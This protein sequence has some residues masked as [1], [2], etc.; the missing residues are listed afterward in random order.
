VA[1]DPPVEK[2][3][4]LRDMGW[5]PFFQQQLTL[6][7]AETLHPA[8][9]FAIQRTH[10]T[11]MTEAGEIEVSLGGRWFQLDV[12]ERPTVGDWVLIPPSADSIV[13]LLDRKSLLKR[14]S[15]GQNS[16]VQLIGANIDTLFLVTSCNA[17]FNPRR[18]ERYLALAYNAGV[19][20]VVVLTKADLAEDPDSY[21][22]EVRKVKSDLVVELVNALEGET[23][24][25]LKG[26]C[27]TGQT[28][29]LLGSSGV[30]K[31]TLVNTLSAVEVQATQGIREDDGKGRHTTTHR[32][33]HL[34]PEG[35]LVLD[36]P[37]MRELAIAEVESGVAQMFDDVEALAAQCRFADCGHDTEPGCAVRGAIDSG[38][39]D[40]A[41]LTSYLK[42]RRE[43]AYNT[44]SIAERHAR[45]RD[46]AKMVK[47]SQGL[48]PKGR[49]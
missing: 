25:S 40:E 22:D 28:V 23:I 4:T 33:L 12:E 35:G 21:V 19:E 47:R 14:M 18:L 1:N 44:E 3:L 8:R 24:G 27:G 36:S 48:S 34:L 42:L 29:A 7:E 37:G 15:A 32:S 2:T 13:R 49:D 46:W 17:D 45:N 20:P 6:E 43:E 16:E 5:A 38:E 31:S 26:W 39:L 41:R 9:V 30:G 10:I 11:L